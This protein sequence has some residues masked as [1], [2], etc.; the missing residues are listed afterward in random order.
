MEI[1]LPAV[2]LSGRKDRNEASNAVFFLLNPWPLP[3]VG[4][5]LQG[6][7]HGGIV[8]SI[9]VSKVASGR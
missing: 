6:R 4:R 8:G 9:G 7:G 1:G 3:Y 5:G 2:S